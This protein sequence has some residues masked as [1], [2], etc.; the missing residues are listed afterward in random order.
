MDGLIWQNITEKEEGKNIAKEESE[1]G[2]KIKMGYQKMIINGKIV[3][4]DERI[5]RDRRSSTK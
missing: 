4:G 2:D 3:Q 1:K 5:T